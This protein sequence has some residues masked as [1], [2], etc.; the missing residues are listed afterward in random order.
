[1]NHSISMLSIS[2]VCPVVESAI[3]D[4]PKTIA[5]ITVS[6]AIANG[7]DNLQKLNGN[8]C[9]GRCLSKLV[10]RVFVA[11]ESLRILRLKHSGIKRLKTVGGT[12]GI[13]T[14]TANI[15]QSIVISGYGFSITA[16][17]LTVIKSI[18]KT[19][20]QQMMTLPISKCSPKRNTTNYTGQRCE[21]VGLNGNVSTAESFSINR[22]EVKRAL[23]NTVRRNVT[24][25]TNAAF[26]LEL[27]RIFWRNAFNN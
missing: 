16:Q 4:G 7:Q 24:S 8:E 17:F 19:T 10:R 6:N 18:T 26:R 23:E 14:K 20:I 25:T 13:G 21:S 22:R 11:V 12:V 9:V 5:P 15:E 27:S 2:S 1:M 3:V